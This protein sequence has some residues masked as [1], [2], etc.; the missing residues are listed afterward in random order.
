MNRLGNMLM[1]FVL[2]SKKRS[3]GG[4]GQKMDQKK[5]NLLLVITSAFFAILAIILLVFGIV[6]DKG[7]FAKIM[8]FV[9]F[10][11]VLLLA[12]ELAYLFVL[13][14]N[15]VP[16]YFLFN[17]A[18]N[19]NVSADKLTF[20][21]IDARMNKYL[22]SFAKSEAELF[23]NGILENS[24]AKIKREFHPIVS[25]K[26]LLDLAENDTDDA[27][28]CFVLAT[29][30]TIEYIAIGL[31]QNGDRD[32]ADAIRQLKRAKPVNLKQTRDFLVSNKKYIKK[33][34][35]KYVQDNIDS[36]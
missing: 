28:K 23:T 26:L 33:R 11:L 10:L 18:L 16:N 22:S 19:V 27:W 35:F 31:A 20:E 7:A 8:L 24:A 32:M 9:A 34:L 36:F 5:T 21:M 6:Y 30:M 4:K 3:K 13:S 1:Q 29:E 25:Y 14:R 17:T 15:V 2:L 12:I